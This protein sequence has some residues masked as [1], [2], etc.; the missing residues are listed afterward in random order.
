MIQD[1]LKRLL[2]FILVASTCLWAESADA[3]GNCSSDSDEYYWC[4]LAVFFGSWAG[5]TTGSANKY[6]DVR[7]GA[8]FIL[9]FELQL[10]RVAVG[11]YYG[12]GLIHSMPYLYDGVAL[13]ED[14]RDNEET[15]ESMGI[16]LGYA[17]FTT[18]YLEL[19]PF[20]GFGGNYFNNGLDDMVFSTFVT[21]GNID[22][23][24]GANHVK[25]T[26]VAFELGFMLRLKYIAEFGSYSDK[27]YTEAIADGWHRSVEVK[28]NGYFINHIFAI[29]LGIAIW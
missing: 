17:V 15:D 12:F 23:R 4:D 21:G 29:S 6:L 10:S 24:L 13:T 3:P 11:F 14:D 19:Q 7:L 25:S 2:F 9:D 8:P 1:K 27:Y 20:V 16:T 26:D 18:P 28:Q 5:T 22:I